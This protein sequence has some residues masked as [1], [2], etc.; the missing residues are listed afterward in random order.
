[1]AA[2]YRRSH[3]VKSSRTKMRLLSC[4]RLLKMRRRVAQQQHQQERAD[5]GKAEHHEAVNVGKHISL[6][7]HRAREKGSRACL[8]FRVS[9]GAAGKSSRIFLQSLVC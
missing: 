4:R 7:L 5:D 9:N 2:Q 8:S 6:V 1:M 3:A